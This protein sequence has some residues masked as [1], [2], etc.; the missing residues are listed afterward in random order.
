MKNKADRLISS[1]QTTGPSTRKTKKTS[2]PATTGPLRRLTIKSKSTKL[3]RLDIRMKALGF[4]TLVRNM[5]GY[6]SKGHTAD[7]L[8]QMT[9]ADG[10]PPVDIRLEKLKYLAEG[11]P[12]LRYIISQVHE[13]ILRDTTD[14]HRRPDKLLIAEDTPLVAWFWELVLTFMYV[15][16]KVLHS[17]LNNDER[18]QLVKSFNSPKS[19]LRVLVLM[20]NVGSQGTNLDSCCNRVVVATGA[21]NASLEILRNDH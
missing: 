12:A 19:T 1:I 5:Q 9:Y 21:I 8:K 16:T 11:S 4:D 6:R 17:G 7:W 20:Y 15:E 13:H 10:D 2:Y 3:G 14:P 18:T